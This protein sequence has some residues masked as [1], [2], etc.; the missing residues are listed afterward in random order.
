MAP[1][2]HINLAV[3]RVVDAAQTKVDESTTEKPIDGDQLPSTTQVLGDSPLINPLQ[4]AVSLSGCQENHCD[5]G[6]EGKEGH[7]APGSTRL[8][9]LLCHL[10]IHIMSQIRVGRTQ[11]VGKSSSNHMTFTIKVPLL[12]DLEF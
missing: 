10:H 11:V 1:I 12:I 4:L 2:D 8:V 9:C 5:A 3:Q 6:D 7:Q